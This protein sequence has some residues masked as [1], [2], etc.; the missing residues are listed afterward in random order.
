MESDKKIVLLTPGQ[1][2]SNPRLLKEAIFLS[3]SGYQVTVIYCFWAHWAYKADISITNRYHTIQWIEVGGNPYTSRWKYLYTRLRHKIFRYLYRFFPRSLF[4]AERS[5][6]RAFSEMLHAALRL[7]ADI[8]I[9][10]NLGALPVAGR[11]AERRIVSFAFDAE[12]FHR[13]QCDYQSINFLRTCLIEDR[14]VPRVAYLTTAS[15]LFA[16]VYQRLYSIDAVVVLNSF[17]KNYLKKKHQTSQ[18]S[19]KLFWFSQTIGKGRGIE[20]VIMAMKLL[21]ANSVTLTLL[22]YC[23]S[24]MRQTLKDLSLA[25]DTPVLFFEVIEPVSPDQIFEIAS[26]YDVGLALEPGRD[27]NNEMAISN[28]IFTYLTS[29]NAVVFSDTRGQKYFYEKFPEVGSIYERGNHEQL[30]KI[31]LEYC[32]NRDLLLSHKNNA[33]NLVEKSINWELECLTIKNLISNL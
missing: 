6:L 11:A 1:P 21:P 31:L 33:V 10:H 4:F 7:D 8:Y 26:N 18:G 2:S 32:T 25:G 14:Y 23:S 3:E 29:G 17:S 22:G 9:A 24:D 15:P 30:A 12:D 27:L 13:G 19:L 5:E 28:K 16:E 20:D